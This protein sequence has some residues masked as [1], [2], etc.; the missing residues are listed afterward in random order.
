MATQ[1][2]VG[3]VIGGCHGFEPTGNEKVKNKTLVAKQMMMKLIMVVGRLPNE[4]SVWILFGSS[5]RVV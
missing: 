3:S 4:E 1:R 5:N 2:N